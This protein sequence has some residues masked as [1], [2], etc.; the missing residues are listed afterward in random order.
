MIPPGRMA[1]F[2]APTGYLD[3]TALPAAGVA[4]RPNGELAIVGGGEAMAARLTPDDMDALA[5]LL[6]AVADQLRNHAADTV[7]AELR[8]LV[9]ARPEGNA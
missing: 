3:A 8:A 1:F 5:E 4:L 9:A 2:P 7:T 6:A